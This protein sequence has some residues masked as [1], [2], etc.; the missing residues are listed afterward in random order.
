MQLYDAGIADIIAIPGHCP[1]VVTVTGHGY[2]DI[3]RGEFTQLAWKGT[4]AWAGWHGR[5]TLSE[6]ALVELV[7]QAGP[8][9]PV[10]KQYEADMEAALAVLADTIEEG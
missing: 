3:R 6:A 5:T 4:G 2:V 7:Y 9:D 1:P 8:D 10:R